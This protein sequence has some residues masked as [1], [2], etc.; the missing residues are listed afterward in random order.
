MADKPLSTRFLKGALQSR[1][2]VPSSSVKFSTYQGFQFEGVISPMHS[3]FSIC[4][5]VLEGCLI[6]KKWNPVDINWTLGQTLRFYIPFYFLLA[7]CFLAEDAML[8]TTSCSCQ[9]VFPSLV[10]F[11]PH[12]MRQNKSV[13]L[14]DHHVRYL[15]IAKG[16][17]APTPS[18][19][20]H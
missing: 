11:I 4:V 20:E 9:H 13:S 7:L 3:W 19:S 14:Q 16:K 12:T 8:P 2:S 6:F 10:F 5:S 15:M 18:F 17:I 1:Q